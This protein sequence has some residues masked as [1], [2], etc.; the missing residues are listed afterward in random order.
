[1]NPDLQPDHDLRELFAHQRRSDHEQAPAWNPGV[2]RAPAKHV[3]SRR[4]AWLPITATAAACVLG[5]LFWLQEEP[6]P[7][8]DL[9]QALPEFF[10]PQGEPLFA[11]LDTAPGSMPSDSLLPAYLNIQLP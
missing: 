5:S 1:M 4:S 3:R 7:P 11:S 10:A 9:A 2:L 8:A 6:K